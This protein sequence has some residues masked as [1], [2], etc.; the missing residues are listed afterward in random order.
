MTEPPPQY[1]EPDKETLEQ[2]IANVLQQKGYSAAFA[3]SVIV[4]LSATKRAIANGLPEDAQEMVK[5]IRDSFKDKGITE[6]GA[7]HT[8]NAIEG[9]AGLPSYLRFPED[10]PKKKPEGRSGP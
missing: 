2:E 4:A 7:N 10:V 9:K 1:T 3:D 6:A 8:T 5:A